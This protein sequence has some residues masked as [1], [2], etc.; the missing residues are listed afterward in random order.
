MKFRQ[1]EQA[2]SN[3]LLKSGSE[4]GAEHFAGRLGQSRSSARIGR[5]RI[6]CVLCLAWTLLELVAGIDIAEVARNL[7]T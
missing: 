5:S 7:E 3:E 6:H 2:E 4:I 1:V